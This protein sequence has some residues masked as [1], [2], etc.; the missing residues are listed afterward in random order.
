MFD[1]LKQ[2]IKKL[3]PISAVSS[4][5]VLSALP[6]HAAEAATDTIDITTTFTYVEQVWTGLTS[7][8]THWLQWMN[9]NPFVLIPVAIFLIGAAVSFVARL[10]RTF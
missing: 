3:F 2:K 1:R 9:A 6:A 5:A 8:I 10:W 4:I 7:V